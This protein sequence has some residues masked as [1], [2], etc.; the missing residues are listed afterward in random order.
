MGA[1]VQFYNV[2]CKEKDL[3]AEADKLR[4]EMR[5]EHGHG[6]YTGTI[7]EDN[8]E[9]KLINKPMS[10]DDA[11]DYIFD[12]AEKWEASLAIPIKDKEN[13]YIIGG[14]YSC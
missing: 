4:A 7:A 13:E 3:D 8:G 14:C 11:E 6:G 12:H 9:L 5:Y 2:T 10:K 1:D